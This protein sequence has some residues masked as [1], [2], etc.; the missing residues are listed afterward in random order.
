MCFLQNGSPPALLGAIPPAAQQRALPVAVPEDT[1]DIYP[2]ERSSSPVFPS[3]NTLFWAVPLL[4][5]LFIL[6]LCWCIW[7]RYPK[8]VSDP[9]LHSPV[10]QALPSPPKYW[11]SWL[12]QDSTCGKV[13]ASSEVIT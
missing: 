2:D 7:R 9:R 1:Q 12:P 6:L 8:S 11:D 5:L 3:F 4:V 10:A 13:P